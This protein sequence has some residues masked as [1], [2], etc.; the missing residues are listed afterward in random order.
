MKY[1]LKLFIIFTLFL[2]NVKHT[3]SQ[4]FGENYKLI[5]FSYTFDS[6]EFNSKKPDYSKWIKMSDD[7]LK[8]IGNQTGIDFDFINTNAYKKY[9]RLKFKLYT[10]SI[11]TSKLWNIKLS[12]AYELSINGKLVFSNGKVSIEEKN[13]KLN[14]IKN[15]IPFEFILKNDTNIFEIT[16][17]KY[18]RNNGVIIGESTIF[19]PIKQDSI[20]T[21]LRLLRNTILGTTYSMFLFTLSIVFFIIFLMYRKNLNYLYFSIFNLFISL[22]VFQI[23]GFSYFYNIDN[24]LFGQL[25]KI[26]PIIIIIIFMLFLPVNMFFSE[27]K[28]IKRVIYSIISILL[29]SIFLSIF[30]PKV[31]YLF[32]LALVLSV[33]FSLIISIIATRKKK[34][35]AAIIGVGFSFP[36]VIYILLFIINLILQGSSNIS[37]SSSIQ[38]IIIILSPLSIP[39]CMTIYLAREMAL[40]NRSLEK[41]I[42]EIK[43]LS[44]ENIEREKEKQRMIEG[45]NALLERQVKE[46]TAEIQSQKEEILTQ[47]EILNQSKEEIQAQNDEITLHRDILAKQKK[48][49]IDSINYAA[50]IQNAVLPS[51]EVF[52]EM[53]PDYFV[54]FKPK[55]IVSGDFY[56]IKKI[57]NFTILAIADCTGHGVPGAFMSMLGISFLN[58]IVTRASID[59]TGLILDNLRKKIKHTLK[60][61]N[62]NIN[63]KDGMDIVLISID[64]ESLELQYSGANNPLYIIRKNGLGIT[65]FDENPK[66]ETVQS[67]DAVLF[68]FK[69]DRQPV[70][71]HIVEK[72]FTTRNFQLQKD[73]I[74]Y[75]GSDGYV[76]QFGG[77]KY[78]K[79][80][81]KNFKTLLLDNYTKPLS[82]QKNI[83]NKTIED[84]KNGYEQIDDILVVGVRI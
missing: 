16:Y 52:S 66:I 37:I 27:N 64:N 45:Q 51:N 46:R 69:P 48:D 18:N 22:L 30:I 80:M 28:K 62:S 81:S 65:N 34:S 72:E 53:L 33:I 61:N 36:L 26:F 56:W 15:S 82:E 19:C 35:G 10:D 7:T 70:A 79:F 73:D 76:D 25:F 3:F 71:V 31:I 55:N 57:K 40:N 42:I 49:I 8:T 9:G 74:L 54:L 83:L 4:E 41:Q 14:N 24:S 6:I 39:L 17:S 11:A 58:E 2:F 5:E 21:K 32:A 38:I 12:L 63:Q 59:S 43:Q 77:N 20:T 84:W 75:A 60:Q 47:N 50:K 78:K 23:T 68:E 1:L 44:Q 29:L 13:V 67:D